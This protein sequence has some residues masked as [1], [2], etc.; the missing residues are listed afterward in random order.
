MLSSFILYV[1]EKMVAY[2]LELSTIFYHF[3][4][5]FNNWVFFSSCVFLL[6]ILFM[7]L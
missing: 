4:K 2:I 6:S 3:L 1:V 7:L 5:V